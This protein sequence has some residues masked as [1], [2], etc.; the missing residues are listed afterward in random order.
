MNFGGEV[1]NSRRAEIHLPREQIW[2]LRRLLGRVAGGETVQ[3]SPRHGP[4]LRKPMV[5]VLVPLRCL[6]GAVTEKQ[7]FKKYQKEKITIA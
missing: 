4:G 1:G 6:I 7:V 5:S 2:G 3:A